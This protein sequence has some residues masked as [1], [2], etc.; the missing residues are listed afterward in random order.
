MAG[1]KG[2]PGGPG[3]RPPTNRVPPTKPVIFYLSF[4]LV[5]YKTDSLKPFLAQICTKLFSGCGFAPDPTGG[6]HS[7]PSNPLAGKGEGKG[8]GGEGKGTGRGREARGG[9]LLLNLSM[10]ICPWFAC[11]VCQRCRTMLVLHF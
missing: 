10:A 8:R 4:M 7:A 1:F 9:C 5:V 2:G 3:P 11:N 6:A